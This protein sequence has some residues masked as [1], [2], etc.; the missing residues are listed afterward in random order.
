[1]KKEDLQIKDT[2]TEIR[3]RFKA[4]GFGH[5][6]YCKAYDFTQ[7]TLTRILDGHLTGAQNNRSG[8]TR[9]IIR[10]LYIDG[11]WLEKPTWL[12]LPE[13]KVS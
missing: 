1:M 5:A 13:E 10:Q 9:R 3:K 8:D 6:A 2:T 12:I 11:V 4:K 7:T